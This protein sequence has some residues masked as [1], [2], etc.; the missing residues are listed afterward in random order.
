MDMRSY[1]VVV[2]TSDIRHAG[3]NANV[4]LVVLALYTVHAS[5]SH[6]ESLRYRF[7]MAAWAIRAL[8]SYSYLKRVYF[9]TNF[10]AIR[11]IPL[12]LCAATSDGNFPHVAIVLLRLTLKNITSNTTLVL[13][14]ERP[15]Q[16]LDKGK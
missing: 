14:L 12:L 8:P 15:D 7:C 10:N 9:R 5:M 3:T 13:R 1:R 11:R 4:D 6:S 16:L 2:Y